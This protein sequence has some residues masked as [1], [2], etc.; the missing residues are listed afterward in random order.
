MPKLTPAERA[1]ARDA[2]VEAW[3]KLGKYKPSPTLAQFHMDGFDIRKGIIDKQTGKFISEP[4]NYVRCVRGPIGSGKSVACVYEINVRAMNQPAGP[5]GVRRSRI[6]VVRDTFINLKNT[7]IQTWLDWFPEGAISQ[8]MWTSPVKIRVQYPMDDGTKVDLELWCVGVENDAQAENLKGMELT[9]AWINECQAIRLSL[10]NQIISRVGRYPGGGLDPEHKSISYV[11]MDTNSPNIGSWYEELAEKKKPMGWKFYTQ[12]PALLWKEVQGGG[13]QYELNVGQKKGVLPA[14]NLDNLGEGGMYYTKVIGSWS[15]DLIKVLICNEYG[16]AAG[17]KP[18]YPMYRDSVHASQVE[19]S[20]DPTLPLV[21]GFDYGLTPACVVVQPNGRGGA[22]VLQEILGDNIG[23]EDFLTTQ[24]IPELQTKYGWGYGLRLY[25]CGDPSGD[26]RKD[27]DEGTTAGVLLRHGIP[28][29]R[30]ITNAISPRLEAVR[31]PLSTRSDGKY[32]DLI[33]DAK[34]CPWLREGFLGN[35]CYK[36]FH[37]RN[38]DVMHQ[39]PDKN[40]YSHVHDAL[41]YA[42]HMVMNPHQYNDVFLSQADLRKHE[43]EMQEA[44]DVSGKDLDLG[45]FF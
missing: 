6:A 27:T 11:I 5:D 13:I 17:G 22:R 31:K 44:Q 15:D 30:C 14:E 8:V 34:G 32:P 25:A 40:E 35:Y 4:K 1:A 23:A 2:T 33:I 36:T 20:F 3:K 21:L 42:M 16:E 28:V 43:K 41:Q 9:G 26:F 24:V 39:V 19:L 29:Q 18:V 37:G 45:A 7:T 12:P 10:I 38:R